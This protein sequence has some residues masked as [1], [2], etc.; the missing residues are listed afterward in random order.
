LFKKS[1]FFEGVLVG[2]NLFHFFSDSFHQLLEAIPLSALSKGETSK[3]D[4]LFS[5]LGNVQTSNIIRQ[6]FEKF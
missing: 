4:G 3:L 5:T 6:F 2:V 1:Q